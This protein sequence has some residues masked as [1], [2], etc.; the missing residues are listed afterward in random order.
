MPFTVDGSPDGRPA[1]RRARNRA[2]RC[3][4]R[5]GRGSSRC[6]RSGS[7]SPRPGRR[8]ADV[9]PGVRST[10]TRPP[11]AWAWPRHREFTR[12]GLQRRNGLAFAAVPLDRIA[13][14]E[15]AEV[16]LAAGV[17]DWVS[18]FSGGDKSSAVGE[19]VRRFEKAHLTVRPRRRA[20][21][22]ARMLAAL[23]TLEQA[24]GRSGR[25]RE[26]DP[27]AVRRARRSSW[28]FSRQDLAPPSCGSRSVWP[29]A[30]P[31]REP[32]LRGSLPGPCGRS[33]CR[34]ILPPRR[35]GAARRAMAGRSGG[36]RVRAA[37]AARCACRRAGLAVP[38]RGCRAGSSRSSAACRHSAWASRCRRPICTRSPG[39]SLR[40]G[41]RYVAAGV[42]GAGRRCIRHGM[43]DQD[44]FVPVATLGLLH[45]LAMGLASGA[46]RETASCHVG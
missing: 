25:A 27:C 34:S 33:C 30:P 42:P 1:E 4:R 12:Y 18:R 13:V 39:G 16:R 11:A 17:E 22:L 7:C 23:T 37:A 8:G 41:A 2:V 26:T 19:A 20:V 14:R 15:K 43:A 36:A 9:P 46:A 45:P 6:R 38:Y 44:P 28:R 31:F 32:I 35:S 3:G 10:S 40:D 29:P 21:Q 24:V 5:S